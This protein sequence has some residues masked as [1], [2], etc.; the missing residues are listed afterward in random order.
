MPS[1]PPPPS[2]ATARPAAVTVEPARRLHPM[3]VVRGIPLRA[4]GQLVPALVFGAAQIGAG[5][6][7]VGVVLVLLGLGITGAIRVLAWQRHTYELTGEQVVERRGIVNRRERTVQVER[8]QQVE[9]D[10][11][12]LDRLFDTAVLRFETASDASEPELELTV[13]SLAEAHRL[14]ETLLGNATA[15]GAAARERPSRT[16]VEV[17]MVHVALASVTGKQLFVV[18]VVLIALLSTLSE[19]G[20]VAEGS[21]TATNFI[22][23]AGAAAVAGLAVA[24]LAVSVLAALAI[25]MLRDGEFRIREV[26]DDLVVS[27]GTVATREAVVPRSRVQLLTV[28]RGW[29]RRRL[30]F[31]TV[32]IHSAG[33]DGSA[34]GQTTLGAGRRLTVPLLLEEEVAPLLHALLPGYGP[35]PQLHPHPRQ[36][37]RR[38]RLRYLLGVTPTWPIAWSIGFF[39]TGSVRLG[40]LVVIGVVLVGVALAWRLG[41][42]DHRNRASGV[43]ERW[44]ASRH[45]ALSITESLG[46]ARK[47]QGVS[48]RTSPFQR[49][50]DLATLTVHVAGP[51]KALAL[52]D[53]R[54]GVA[55]GAAD[56]LAG[57][58]SVPD[59]TDR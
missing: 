55:V 15:G 49:R 8:L 20:L 52:V 40:A 1:D 3:T 50:L 36:A 28:D 21:D 11:N 25:G 48:V 44:V 56:R 51:G 30:G 17:P 13:V 5:S 18:P 38:A 45:G 14:R 41:T 57:R 9:V 19:A 34:S 2:L 33:G 29:F 26:G 43:G 22:A 32:T 39:L 47:A 54:P 23:A 16:L 46:P 12:I 24:L 53:V 37:A 27:R 35:L 59:A 42:L 10:Q 31:A 7:V 4:L 58:W 6:V